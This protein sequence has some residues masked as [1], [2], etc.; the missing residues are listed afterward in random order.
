[1]ALDELPDAGVGYAYLKAADNPGRRAVLLRALPGGPEVIVPL[2]GLAKA[3]STTTEDKADAAALGLVA[4]AVSGGEVAI[5]PRG[6]P[7]LGP[8]ARYQWTSAGIALEV[9]FPQYAAALARAQAHRIGP[10][11]RV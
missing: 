3:F 4:V 9:Q 5:K 8:A 1:V 6:I 11:V 2:A 7:G 10:C